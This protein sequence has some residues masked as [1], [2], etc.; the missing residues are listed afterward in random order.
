M[1]KIKSKTPVKSKSKTNPHIRPISEFW[2]EKLTQT[3]GS[4]TGDPEILEG[5][6]A[7]M[8]DQRLEGESVQ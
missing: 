5:R 6:G 1:K 2:R 4:G 3:K 8:V 7:K